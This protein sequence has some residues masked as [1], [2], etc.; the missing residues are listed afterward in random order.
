MVT[1]VT[2]WARARHP[3]FRSIPTTVKTSEN[4]TVLLPCY[5]DN[6]GNNIV[7]WW[8]DDKLLADSSDPNITT[9]ARVTM[10]PNNTLQVEEL[11]PEDT[12]EYMCQVVR[13]APWNPIQQMHAIEVLYPPS[14]VPIPES[15]QVIVEL[16]DEVKMACEASGVPHPIITWVTKGEELQLLDNRPKLRFIADNRT[17]AGTYE[18]IAS[19]GVGEPA[20]AVI[21]LRILYPPEVST[22]RNW[23][24]ASPGIRAE[25]SCMVTADP[26][27]EVQWLKDSQLLEPR[28]H[29]ST[30]HYEDKFRLLFRRVQASDFGHYMCRATNRIG[31]NQQTIQLSGVANPAVFKKDYKIASENNYTL[32]WEVD[33]YSPIIEYNLLFRKYHEGTRPGPWVKLIIPADGGYV[34]GQLHSKSYTLTGLDSSSTYE[35]TLL[36]RNVFGWSRPSSVL[37]FSTAG[38]GVEDNE[39][40]VE[41]ETHEENKL[42]PAEVAAIL[43]DQNCA[44]MSHTNIIGILLILIMLLATH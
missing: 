19:N 25:I 29:I 24:H 16:G 40:V 44:S 14:V 38:E 8:R 9:P 27:A 28:Q 43:R 41:V 5:V 42:L 31:T 3:Q 11:R 18:C 10:F 1:S 37:R 6:L 2:A 4:D 34:P 32:I 12:G 13:P 17:M 7:R 20:R 36:S 26:E 39:L 30:Y 21:E 23:V 22:D 15:G 33:S 35:V